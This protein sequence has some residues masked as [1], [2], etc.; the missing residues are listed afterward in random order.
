MNASTANMAL[1]SSA[2]AEGQA[3]PKKYTADGAD[4]SPP[5][6]W[7]DVPDGTREFALICDDPD[8][9]TPKPWVHWV[10]YKLPGELRS[11]A[12]AIPP[13]PRLDEPAAA[14]QGANS[15]SSGQ[16]IGYRGPAPPKGTHRYFFRIYA[17]DAPLAV[18]AGLTKDELL[19][20]MTGHVLAEGVL[21][22]TYAR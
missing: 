9:P 4:V 14:L 5:L 3:I 16:K 11:L 10:I 12:E 6:A 18:E 1:T 19:K 13:Q 15:W 21:M 2:F 17:L 8:A 7:S 22:G 20:A